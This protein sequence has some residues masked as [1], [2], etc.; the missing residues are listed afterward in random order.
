[1]SVAGFGA[2]RPLDRDNIEADIN[3]RVEV[4]VVFVE[5][6]LLHASK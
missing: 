2:T 3:R 5:K 1:V 6:A 4:R